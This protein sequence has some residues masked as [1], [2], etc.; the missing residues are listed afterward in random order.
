LNGTIVLD[1]EENKE[2]LSVYKIPTG[3]KLAEINSAEIVI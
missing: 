3:I 2:K 1:S